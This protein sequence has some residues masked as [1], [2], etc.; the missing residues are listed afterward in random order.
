M[1]SAPYSTCVVCLSFNLAEF[2]ED[3]WAQLEDI[4]ITSGNVLMYCTSKKSEM[5]RM[6]TLYQ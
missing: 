3:R 2:A 6:S 1:L 5:G 4:V